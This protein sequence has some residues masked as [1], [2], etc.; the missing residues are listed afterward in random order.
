MVIGDTVTYK[1]RNDI[2][3]FLNSK[4]TA[5]PR[6][7]FIT[8]FNNGSL[9][10]KVTTGPN[11][12]IMIGESDNDA[13]NIRLPASLLIVTAPKLF[14]KA[15][16]LRLKGITKTKIPP[17]FINLYMSK[18]AMLVNSKDYYNPTKDNVVCAIVDS[19]GDMKT[20]II[21][22]EL[23][24]LDLKVLDNIKAIRSKIKIGSFIKHEGKARKVIRIE[25]AD[26]RS[27]LPLAYI[28][29]NGNEVWV[30]LNTIGH[31]ELANLNL[32]TDV[33]DK[34]NDKSRLEPLPP[35]EK[36]ICVTT[37]GIFHTYEKGYTLTKADANSGLVITNGFKVWRMN[38]IDWSFIKSGNTAY[39][40][41][42]VNVDI[43]AEFA[44]ACKDDGK[45]IILLY[46]DLEAKVKEAKASPSNDLSFKRNAMLAFKKYSETYNGKTI[47][48][49]DKGYV[50]TEK[51]MGNGLLITNGEHIWIAEDVEYKHGFF[52]A[53][54]NLLKPYLLYM[55]ANPIM[56]YSSA[57]EISKVLA[58]SF[59]GTITDDMP[60]TKT[61]M[62]SGFGTGAPAL[63]TLKD[64]LEMEEAMR[65][66]WNVNPD[67]QGIDVLTNMADMLASLGANMHAATQSPE[68]HWNIMGGVKA[69]PK[70]R[71]NNRDD[72]LMDIP[73]K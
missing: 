33:A 16:K 42:V 6:D 24:H 8:R 61:G 73:F 26:Y 11:G 32:F 71:K 40:Y 55:K 57:V 45:T 68:F 70:P 47:H 4:F 54:A 1:N 46:S 67:K 53:D 13:Y 5:R 41:K 65:R 34:V 29:S 38:D 23:I 60:I 3:T 14:D 2:K 52:V 50:I 48:T 31:V 49:Y 36:S 58:F 20:Y 17:Y 10:V 25:H 27:L 63:L 19:D 69:T 64:N 37:N 12:T 39:E 51:D 72:L 7:R 30:D 66:A 59:N 15:V 44:K 21:S 22:K 28:N 56:R 9:V 43:L 18:G 62:I 35:N